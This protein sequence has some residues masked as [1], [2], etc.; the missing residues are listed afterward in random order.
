MFLIVV[1]PATDHLLR[2]VAARFA[3]RIRVTAAVLA[4][5]LPSSAL[6]TLLLV[7][8]WR[9]LEERFRIESVGHSGPALWCYL[10]VFLT[11]F[12][13]T[14]CVYFLRKSRRLSR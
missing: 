5:S 7:P 9:H 6:L 2:G 14:G 1:E 8:F 4:L 13:V 10:V 3:R 11:L 12:S